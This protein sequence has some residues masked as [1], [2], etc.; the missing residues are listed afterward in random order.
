MVEGHGFAH[1]RHQTS[2]FFAMEV[3]ASQT[4]LW[5]AIHPLPWEQQK[6]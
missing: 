5:D 4:T 3:N 2:H 1:T 6:G